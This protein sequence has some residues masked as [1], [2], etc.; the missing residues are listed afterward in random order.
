MT[1]SLRGLTLS[2]TLYSVAVLWLS[3]ACFAQLEPSAMNGPTDEPRPRS[4]MPGVMGRNEGSSY[5]RVSPGT[6]L[7]PRQITGKPFSV[8]LESEQTQT[9]ADGTNITRK[10]DSWREYRDSLGRTRSEHGPLFPGQEG[11]KILM[12]QI[13][14]PVVGIRYMFGNQNRIAHSMPVLILRGKEVDGTLGEHSLSPSPRGPRRMSP[15]E[16]SGE[17][18]PTI[19]NEPIGTETFDG[20]SADGVRS[21]MTIPA[22]Y[23]GNDRPIQSTCE[24]WTSAELQMVVMAN[25]SDPRTGESTM[26]LSRVEFSEPDPLLFQVPSGYTIVKDKAPPVRRTM[27]R[28]VAP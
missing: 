19:D 5:L 4:I 22:G 12:I 28:V 20:I 6:G 25:C 11:S 2:T 13:T 18:H 21:T 3:S 15:A 14:D 8:V 26:R 17:L 16:A 7:G 9:L 23:M 24:R 10:N 27:R 1:V